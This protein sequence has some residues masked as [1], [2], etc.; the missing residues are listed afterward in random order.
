MV[1]TSAP[2]QKSNG[3]ASTAWARQHHRHRQRQQRDR[4]P[5]PVDGGPAA[6]FDQHAAQY[7]PD[8]R[9]ERH[10]HREGR[11]RAQPL[12]RRIKRDRERRRAGDR[13]RRADAL[14]GSCGKEPGPVGRGGAGGAADRRNGKADAEDQAMAEQVAEL[15]AH[16]HQRAVDQ[17]VAD[18]EPLHVAELQLE[19][20][21]D[22]RQRH[23]DGDV[24]RRQRR[25]HADD[26]Q[27]ERRI[28]HPERREGSFLRLQRSLGC[29]PRDDGVGVRAGRPGRPSCGPTPWWRRRHR[30]QGSSRWRRRGRRRSDRPRA[31]CRRRSSPSRS[32]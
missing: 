11:E 28:S 18:H 1:A 7:R 5:D 14:Q 10:R 26:R 22:R 31:C 16:Q 20:R 23:V 2:P 3:R 19:V 32:R 21:R 17:H 15:A 13:Q 8:R 30:R 6:Q 24:E 25:A 4:H 29:C 27:A 12:R 9:G